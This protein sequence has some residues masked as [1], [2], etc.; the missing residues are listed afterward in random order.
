MK[1]RLCLFEGNPMRNIIT[2]YLFLIFDYDQAFFLTS[3][4]WHN[5]PKRGC[6]S[7]FTGVRYLQVIWE[8]ILAFYYHDIDTKS[9][10]RNGCV[11][12]PVQT[13]ASLR[14]TVDARLRFT[15]ACAG[16]K[17][18]SEVNQVCLIFGTVLVQTKGV[19]ILPYTPVYDLSQI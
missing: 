10:C 11:S 13:L 19:L 5:L 4:F 14:R 16:F 7:V 17:A 3:Q 1:I 18:S 2:F 12:C 9:S 8:H 15:Q 6:K